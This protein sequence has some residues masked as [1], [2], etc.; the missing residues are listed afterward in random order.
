MRPC[1][2]GVADRLPED[3][4]EILLSP[5]QTMPQVLWLW[6]GV[7]AL[8]GKRTSTRSEPSAPSARTAVRS[9]VSD[10]VL[11]PVPLGCAEIK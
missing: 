6:I 4:F 3:R 5:A 9:P 10:S 11:M 1:A 8:T 2:V 7:G